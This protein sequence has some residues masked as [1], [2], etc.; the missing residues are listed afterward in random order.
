V[1]SRLDFADF[2]QAEYT[3]LARALYLLT[4]N[5]HEADELAQEALVR[6]YERWERVSAMDSPTGYL[7]RTALNLHRNR[8]RQLAIRARRLLSVATPDN[9]DPLTAVEDRDELGRVLAVMPRTQ[10]EALVLLVWLGLDV[11]EAARIMGKAAAGEI[12]VSETTRALAQPS[13][14]SFDD[15]GSHTLKGLEGERRLYALRIDRV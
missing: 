9:S 15:R 12:L 2:F 6:L 14:F 5:P 1:K 7:Y 4:G 3:R 10:R 8:L 11:D 13:G